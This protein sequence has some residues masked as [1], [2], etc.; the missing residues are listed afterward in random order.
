M[1]IDR[2]IGSIHPERNNLIY[3]VNYGSV[4]EIIGG[5]GEELDVKESI[6]EFAGRD[7]GIIY[8]ENDVEDKLVVAPDGMKFTQD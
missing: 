3:P 7:V 8:R 5:D 4:P 2:P 1:K 6:T